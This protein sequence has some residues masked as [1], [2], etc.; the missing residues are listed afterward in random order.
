[1][2]TD[3]LLVSY[4]LTD[5]IGVWTGKPCPAFQTRESPRE[6]KKPGYAQDFVKYMG[7]SGL[8]RLTCN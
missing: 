3:L 4:L 2:M 1:M 7:G 8:G 5:L 6:P